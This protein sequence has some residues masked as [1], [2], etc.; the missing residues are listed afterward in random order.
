MSI[1]PSW[2]YYISRDQRTIII[3][4]I[5]IQF[6]HSRTVYVGLAQARPN[7]TYGKSISILKSACF[8]GKGRQSLYILDIYVMRISKNANFLRSYI[9]TKVIIM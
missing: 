9:V 3:M 8:S 6:A 4:I 5:Y 2:A 1:E 7:N